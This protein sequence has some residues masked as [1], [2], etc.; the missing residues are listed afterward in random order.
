MPP[1]RVR[2]VLR[3][4]ALTLALPLSAGAQLVNGGFEGC[5][6]YL[7]G[8]NGSTAIN[9]WTMTNQGVEWFSPSAYGAGVAHGGNCAVDLAWYT[10]NGVPGGGIKQTAQTVAGQSY[11]LS[12]WGA[13][14][15]ASGRFGTGIIELWLNGSLAG[16]YNVANNKSYMTLADWL[17][18][19]NTFV[20]T[21]S[22]TDI[23]FRNQQNAYQ[24]FADLDDV[25]L[26]P[27]Q[28]AV[29]E[30]ASLVLVAS[31]I[32]GVALV[33]RRRKA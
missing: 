32:A 13:T 14:T 28:S 30:P 16:S 33:R 2:S 22:T 26:S 12:F 29:P 11:N 27:V 15:A 23:E 7:L 1:T 3:C 19:S 20:A 25:S 17:S 4:F 6:T 9:G 18:F 21:G 24:Y 8:S 5:P 31:G 10:S